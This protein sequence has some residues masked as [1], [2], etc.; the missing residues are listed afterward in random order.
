MQIPAHQFIS[1]SPSFPKAHWLATAVAGT[2]VFALISAII[3]FS[4][5]ETR[6]LLG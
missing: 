1:Q 5:D 4:T 3:F 6:A 2:I